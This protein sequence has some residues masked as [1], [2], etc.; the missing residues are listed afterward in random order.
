MNHGRAWRWAALGAGAILAL[1]VLAVVVDSLF[2]APS[3]PRSSAYA[4]APR[5]LAAYDA[6]LSRSGHPSQRLREPPGRARLDPRSTVVLLDPDRVLPR[7]AG[8]LGAFVRAGGRL[9]AGGAQPAPWLEALVRPA[10]VW[11]AKGARRA[12][13]TGVAPEVAGLRRVS[14]DG[15]GS[16]ARR[17]SAT[18]ILGGDGSPTLLAA[19]VGRGRLLLLA[20]ASP[21]QNRLLGRADNA[22]LGLALA[23]PRSRP[24]A[25]VETVHGFGRQR[26][27]AALPGRWRWALIGLLAALLAYMVAR[28][29]RLGPPEEDARPLPPPRRAYVDAVAGALAGTRRPA[30]ASAPVRAAAR[31]GV[32]QRAALGPDPDD[33]T[34]DASAKRLGLPA[35]ERRALIAPVRDDADV[36][37]AG[38]ALARLRGGRR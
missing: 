20:D 31:A 33:A 8:A 32:A 35:D 5:G 23:G 11:R 13:P 4:T 26:G 16:W 17:G 29:R 3:G 1:N 21:L 24:V 2:A 6:L 9:V 10:P 25:F 14:T 34:L 19:R 15:A 37:A 27:L 36:V 28:G 22:S 30:E 18:P 12:A 7:E 38:R